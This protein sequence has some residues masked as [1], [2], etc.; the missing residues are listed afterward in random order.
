MRYSLL[1][2]PVAIVGLAGCVA[3]G[4]P[5]SQQTSTTNSTSAYAA[6]YMTPE[7]SAK[8]FTLP[9]D[10][11][12]IV[13]PGIGQSSNEDSMLPDADTLRPAGL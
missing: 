2:L 1:L 9:G 5:P 4:T 10:T 6:T 11:T 12:T 3:G 8:L 7:Q 13:D